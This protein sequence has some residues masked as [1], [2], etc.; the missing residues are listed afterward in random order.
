MDWLNVVESANSYRDMATCERLA[1]MGYLR[2]VYPVIFEKKWILSRLLIFKFY[3]QVLRHSVRIPSIVAQMESAIPSASITRTVPYTME[4]FYPLFH[5]EDKL[6]VYLFVRVKFRRSQDKIQYC[7][8]LRPSQKWKRFRIQFEFQLKGN[9]PVCPNDGQRVWVE[10]E[11][12]NFPEAPIPKSNLVI[13]IA[14]HKGQRVWEEFL[15]KDIVS[16]CWSH[17]WPAQSPDAVMVDAYFPVM[18]K[19]TD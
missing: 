2:R 17:Q 8:C 3:R 9:E 18:R 10:N 11:M 16:V 12:F 7:L 14:E 5:F 19:F 1:V 4:A 6:T 15:K 13:P